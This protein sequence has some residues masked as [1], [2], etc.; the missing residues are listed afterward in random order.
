MTIIY[1][2]KT[3]EIVMKTADREEFLAYIK[4]YYQLAQELRELGILDRIATGEEFE[5]QF[6]ELLEL[7]MDEVFLDKT[8]SEMLSDGL[9]ALEKDFMEYG[10]DLE[11]DFYGVRIYKEE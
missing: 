8:K 9:D 2:F 4:D 5:H 6:Y 7:V 11:D 3:R 1:E 10:R